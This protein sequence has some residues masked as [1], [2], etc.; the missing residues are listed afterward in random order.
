MLQILLSFVQIKCK[1]S[2]YLF[3]NCRSWDASAFIHIIIFNLFDCIFCSFAT[4]KLLFSILKSCTSFFIISF[5]IVVLLC[6]DKTKIGTKIAPRF[7]SWRLRRKMQNSSICAIY[8]CVTDSDLGL[9]PLLH[10]DACDAPPDPA[11]ESR[12]DM[13]FSYSLIESRSVC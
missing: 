10:P 1:W 12:R 8:I 3:F 4:D 11:L 5:W 13:K 7:E 6:G 2:W 9:H